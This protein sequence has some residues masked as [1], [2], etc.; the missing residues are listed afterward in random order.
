[1]T[2]AG[3]ASLVIVSRDRAEMLDRC[4]T[5]VMQ[6]DHPAF[7]VIVVTDRPTARLLRARGVAKRGWNSRAIGSTEPTATKPIH[8]SAANTPPP[9]APS[10]TKASKPCW[11]AKYRLVRWNT[12]TR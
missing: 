11:R 8:S 4:L 6:L 5:A 1:M 3:P 2:A 10:R 9:F 12:A 7:E